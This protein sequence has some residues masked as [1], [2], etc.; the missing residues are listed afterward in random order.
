MFDKKPELPHARPDNRLWALCLSAW[1]IVAQMSD[2][3]R[4]KS[5]IRVMQGVAIELERLAKDEDDCTCTPNH[6][7][8]VCN[9]VAKLIYSDDYIKYNKVPS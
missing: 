8:H 9:A 7:C 2:E 4:D 1:K 3:K 5:D 6:D